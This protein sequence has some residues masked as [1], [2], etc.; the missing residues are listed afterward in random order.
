M[1][2]IFAYLSPRTLGDFV[3]YA[4]VASSIKEQFDNSR[5]FI[6]YRPDRPYKEPIVSCIQNAAGV[7]P[8]PPESTGIPL[9]YFDRHHGRPTHNIPYWEKNQLHLTELVLTG[10]MMN[11]LMLNVIRPVPLR[12]PT[13]K[14]AASDQQ[15][16]DLGLD[17]TRWFA[18]IYW[19]EDGY[20]FRRFN[21]VRT[22]SDPAPYLAAIH[23]IVENLGGQVVRLGH[24]TP[25]QIPPLKGVVDLAKVENSEWLQIYAVARSRFLVGSASGPTSYGSAFGVPTVTTDQSL[26]IGAWGEDDYIVTQ[27]I[28]VNG[29]IHRQHEAFDAGYLVENFDQRQ[30]V[31]HRNTARDL[32]AAT[33]EMF[34]VTGDCTQWRSISPYV[35]NGPRANA[36]TL[37]VPRRLRDDLLTPPSIR[38]LVAGD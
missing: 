17:P 1:F 7:I 6:Y 9:D 22:I 21:H 15:L 27:G 35:H 37:P 11:E 36:I 26:C 14:I 5:L 31:Y 23:H 18:T 2:T 20:A 3:T 19:K 38:R 4:T 10:E 29:K 30:A 8:A 32:V 25:T 33:D 16:V 12:P 24:A 13:D 28:E 34:R